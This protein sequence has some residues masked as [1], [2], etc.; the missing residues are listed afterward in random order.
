[1]KALSVHGGGDKFARIS[2]RDG[3]ITPDGVVGVDAEDTTAALVGLEVLDIVAK[4]PRQPPMTGDGDVSRDDDF[5]DAGE[6]LRKVDFTISSPSDGI[7]GG[8]RTDPNPRPLLSRHWQVG[9]F[10]FLGRLVLRREENKTK[11]RARFVSDSVDDDS[12]RDGQ[13]SLGEKEW[14]MRDGGLVCWR[15]PAFSQCR[16]RSRQTLIEEGR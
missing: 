13:V 9:Y 16:L 12:R 8:V 10:N 6:C 14:K 1:M 11:R 7:D 3:G 5:R 4:S 15:T 2:K